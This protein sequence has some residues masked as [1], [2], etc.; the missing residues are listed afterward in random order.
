MRE[1]FTPPADY[2]PGNQVALADNNYV[3]VFQY[4]DIMD[5][6]GKNIWHAKQ[7]EIFKF[8]DGG[9]LILHTAVN[10]D[11]GPNDAQIPF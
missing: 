2:K 9:K 6:K 11:L 8:N 1:A 4:I 5:K 10:E 3:F 7:V